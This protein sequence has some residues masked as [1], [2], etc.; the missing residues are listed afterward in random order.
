MLW[1]TWWTGAPATL[2][3]SFYLQP[4]KDPKDEVWFGNTPIGHNSLDKMIGRMCKIAG[5]K[6]YKTNHSL[7][8]SLAT[9]LFQNGVDEQLIM[10]KTGHR[11][12]DSVRKYKRVGNDQ[13]QMLSQ[14][15]QGQVPQSRKTHSRSPTCKKNV[16]FILCQIC[17]GNYFCR[18]EQRIFQ[19]F[20]FPT[21]LS[22]STL[23]RTELYT[24]PTRLAADFVFFL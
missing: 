15:A 20:S 6:G 2:G 16:R 8:V 12:T 4:L 17:L 3:D 14:V 9:R 11:S 23:S 21:V 1:L 10:A 13:V 22:P 24:R 19:H 5:I 7:R 18:L